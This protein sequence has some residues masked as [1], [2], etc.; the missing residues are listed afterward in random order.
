MKHFKGYAMVY[1][2]I[3]T[4]HNLTNAQLLHL[5][6]LC[7]RFDVNTGS[8]DNWTDNMTIVGGVRAVTVHIRHT[9]LVLHIDAFDRYG[10]T[11]SGSSWALKPEGGQ[12]ATRGIAEI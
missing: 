4:K 6:A 5:H 9:D 11:L 1:E 2:D 12:Y 3:K 10:D 8:I 7:A